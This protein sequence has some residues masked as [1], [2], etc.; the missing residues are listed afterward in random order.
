MPHFPIMIVNFT[1]IAHSVSEARSL[2][3]CVLIGLNM[4]VVVVQKSSYRWWWREQRGMEKK[5]LS[6][7]MASI[8]KDK[9]IFAKYLRVKKTILKVWLYLKSALTQNT[10]LMLCPR[11]ISLHNDY[12][13]RVFRVMLIFWKVKAFT[14]KEHWHLVLESCPSRVPKG[15]YTS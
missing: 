7:E 3:P 4:A 10:S 1:V 2:T 12:W 14:E 8:Y 15:H 13:E 6:W 11:E 9:P 5:S